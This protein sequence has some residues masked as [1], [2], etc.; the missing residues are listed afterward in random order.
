M[1][2]REDGWFVGAARSGR[3]L[4]LCGGALSPPDS[5]YI[6]SLRLP[7]LA[8]FDP[9]IF[10]TYQP[11]TTLTM[12]LSGIN[13]SFVLQKVNEVSFEERPIPALTSP[14]D[15]RIEIK[16]TGICGSDV[17][18]YTHGSIGSFVVKAPMVLGHESAGVVV[19]TGSDVTTLA[20]G[21]RV[22][23]EPGI[24]CRY[25]DNCKAGAY[26]LC[27]DMKFAAT[28]PYDGTLCRYY[29]L[30]EDFCV[31]LPDSVSFEEGALVEPLSVAVH[32]S[33]LAQITPGSSVIVFGAGPIGLLCCAV[34]SAFGA[35]TI[36]AVDLVQ[37]RLD[38]ALEVGATNTFIP[39]K[40]DSAAESA[41]KIKAMLG[42]VAPK[43]A[44]ECSG[45]GASINTAI[46][47]LAQGSRYV[48]VG[49]GA[50]DIMFP[51]SEF[52][53][54]ETTAFGSFRYGPGDY[55]LAVEMIASGKVDVKKLITHR[56]K[57]EEAEAAFKLVMGGKGVK[58]LIE[59]PPPLAA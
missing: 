38:L 31:K 8:S 29:V 45:A 53:V 36:T 56:V 27:P 23:L 21:D 39:T 40:G 48:Q 20:V 34:A 12:S 35:T 57:F 59:G 15:V 11:V 33:R 52:T 55:K 18:Y 47:V 5:T 54:K 42:G 32:V 6:Y 50:S 24:P 19:E 10:P 13:T 46:H 37:S 1:L 3:C 58:I 26:N 41:S 51:I 9:A 17:H 4:R 25:C 49:M 44:L 28:P 30:P 22:A 2:P 16:Q 7:R 43:F 14:R